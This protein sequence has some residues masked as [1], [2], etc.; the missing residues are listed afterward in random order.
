MRLLEPRLD[1]LDQRL[2]LACLHDSLLGERA[3]VD[4]ADRRMALDRLRHERLRI[5]GLVLLVVAE[6][7]VADQID[8]HVVAEALAVGERQP[9]R[10]DRRPRGRRR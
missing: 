2:L 9:D 4:L 8:D 1:G 5:G 10:R 6:A 7:P 3:G